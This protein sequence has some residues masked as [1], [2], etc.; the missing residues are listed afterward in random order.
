MSP[1]Q[2][3]KQTV[4]VLVKQQQQREQNWILFQLRCQRQVKYTGCG[5]NIYTVIKIETSPL[6]L[7]YNTVR[8]QHIFQTYLAC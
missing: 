4:I 2:H 1:L 3:E 7:V 6:F 5:E 8:V